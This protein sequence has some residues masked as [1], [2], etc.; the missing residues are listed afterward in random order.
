ML[1]DLL[2]SDDTTKD[3]MFV[4]LVPRYFGRLAREKF[5]LWQWRIS[6]M[7][8]LNVLL[9]IV[10]KSGFIHEFRYVKDLRKS[11]AAGFI[12]EDM[13]L[14]KESIKVNTKKPTQHK[15]NTLITT[16]ICFADRMSLLSCVPPLRRKMHDLVV[17]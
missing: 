13:D 8:F 6:V 12:F 9:T 14:L 15:I 1:D 17:T 7:A 10:N 4:C 16:T 11:S 3:P 2:N 5:G